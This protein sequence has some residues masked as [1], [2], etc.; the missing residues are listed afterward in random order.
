MQNAQQPVHPVKANQ[1]AHHVI[2]STIVSFL[3]IAV[4]VSMAMN[5]RMGNYYVDKSQASL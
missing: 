5:K 3:A 4:S 2:A 1:N